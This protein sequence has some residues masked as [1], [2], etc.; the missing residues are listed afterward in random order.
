MLMTAYEAGYHGCLDLKDGYAT[1]I[2]EELIEEAKP[3]MNEWFK[4]KSEH[5][6][7]IPL[8]TK[9]EVKKQGYFRGGVG[10]VRKVNGRAKEIVFDN[11]QT[12]RPL[13][14][15]RE[16]LVRILGNI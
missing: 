10:H 2:I 14:I 13:V 9:I 4:I 11:G 15:L 8:G 6:K 5:L 3:V 16:E 1:E 7:E 12:P